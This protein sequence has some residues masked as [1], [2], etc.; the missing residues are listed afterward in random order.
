MINIVYYNMP[1]KRSFI[2]NLP[3]DFIN[4][5]QELLGPEAAAFFDSFNQS[6]P[7]GYRIN[8]NKASSLVDQSYVTNE[9]VPYC[10]D[11]HYGHLNGKSIDHTT[12]YLYSQEPSAMYVGEVADPQQGEKVLDLCAAPGGK[13]THLVA[14]M[15]NSGLLVS[16]E[17][18]K[19][20]AKILA[21][22]LERW[23]AQNTVITNE[24]PE[25]LE[26]QFPAFFDRILVDAPCSGE[27]MFRKDPAA[28]QYWHKDYSNE[29]ANR[30]QHILD[31]A[32]KMMHAGSTLI[33]S[34]CTFAPEE[35]EQ[36]IDWFIR[37]YPQFTLVP[38]KKYSGM[39]DGRPEWGND[40]PE[41]TK[42]V[43][44][45]PHHMKGEGHFI[46]KLVWQAASGSKIVPTVKHPFHSVK[47]SKEQQTELT[48]FLHSCLVNYQI[49]NLALFG[50]QLFDMPNGMP[51]IDKMS[52]V[53]PG[54]HLG[55]FKKRRFEP[56]LGLALA[57]DDDQVLNKLTIT[58][59]QWRQYVHGDTITVNNDYPK[60]W[61]LL[62]CQN[63]AV[64]FGKLVNKTVKNFYPKGL[65]F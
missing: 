26:T 46:A 9:R 47:L 28:T 33:Y 43:R 14:K 42:T 37:K 63:H 49:R 22:N 31:S 15:Q 58:E 11:G 41:L 45:F 57:I 61:Y 35:D 60:G 4:K 55:T 1:N 56:A 50:D 32:V 54:V 10:R 2:L 27:G 24:S 3:Q 16:N 8:S 19:A 38:I 6:S 39:D 29:C 64:C 48:E 17:I 30:Q 18:F 5:Y 65:R 12:G 34:T 13:S 7:G 51:I 23:G 59:E 62:T 40:N 36:I 52:I 44:L 20:R 25:K 53:R 21:E